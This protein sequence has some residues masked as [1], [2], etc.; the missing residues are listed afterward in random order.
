M[1]VTTMQTQARSGSA[2]GNALWIIAAFVAM[3]SVLVINGRPLFYFD[4]IGYI[5]QG[6]NG[7]R[8]LGLRANPRSR[9]KTP[10]AGRSMTEVNGGETPAPGPTCPRSTPRTPS[11]G[12]VR[13]PMRF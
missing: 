11:M 12:R 13:R 5:S 3:F 10:R 9:R 4:T 1:T 2:V 8:Q 7:L 6:H